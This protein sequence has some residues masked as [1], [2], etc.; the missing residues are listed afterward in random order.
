MADFK[1]FS[2]R[3]YAG[4]K[5]IKRGAMA[6]GA[7]ASSAGSAVAWFGTA[8]TL[9]KIGLV[10]GLASPPVAMFAAAGVAGGIIAGTFADQL[11]FKR[12]REWAE[13][14]LKQ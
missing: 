5:A 3:S 14:Y 7:A 1:T 11:L 10:I 8:G 2:I 13:E 9:T 12:D 4:E 6:I